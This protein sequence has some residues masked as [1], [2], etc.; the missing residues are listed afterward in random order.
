LFNHEGPTRGETFV[1]RKITRA[2]AA[3]LAGPLEPTNQWYA[4]AKIA[5]LRL[6]EG[7]RRQ[8]GADF[9]SVM[10]T[11]LYGPG[12]NY[13]PEHSHVPAALIRRM[14]EAKISSA[15]TV[16][17]WGTGKPRRE[18]LAV[19]DLADACIFVL[20]HY[21]GSKFLNVG[22]GK[23]ITIAEFA[24]LVAD[25]VGYHGRFVF[26]TSRPDGVPQKLL[27]VSELTRLGWRAKT[28][29]REGIAQAHADS[30]P[31]WA[32]PSWRSWN[33]A[34][35]RNEQIFDQSVQRFE[36]TSARWLTCFKRG[37]PRC[38]GSYFLF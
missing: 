17:M 14:H 2:A 1:T 37:L 23:D 8:Y 11:N 12:D 33:K 29:L 19:D 31:Q 9:I 25:V 35:G 30:S 32:T 16:T 5:G 21:S 18:F 24:H 7:Y 27:D 34:C 13:H 38:S 10:P 15:P 6:V 20:K 26:D 22:T 3:M 36:C 4:V 28:P